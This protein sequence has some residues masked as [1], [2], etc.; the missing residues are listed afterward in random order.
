MHP[1]NQK[2]V[3]APQSGVAFRM[4]AG[5][6]LKVTDP[7][8]QQVADLYCLD[9][10]RPKDTLSS[11][12]SID[13]NE[14]L[15]FTK[16][17]MLYSHAGHIMLEILEDTCG[18]HDFLITPCTLQMFHMLARNS[19]YHPS[20]EE[21]LIR[22]FR[23]FDIYLEHVNTT[24]NVFMNVVAGES[25]KIQ[26][27]PPLS[28]PNDY[29]IFLAHRDLIVGLTACSHEGTNNGSCKPIEYEFIDSLRHTSDKK[30]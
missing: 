28:K 6:A 26:I 23:P 21:N 17:E 29:V 4:S 3:I 12:R 14:T 1:L 15:Y 25:G 7:H 5:E 24:F 8:G 11:G 10:V 20:C 13:Y 9:G 16:G 2:Q 18:R 30:E 22:H 19:E 27:Q